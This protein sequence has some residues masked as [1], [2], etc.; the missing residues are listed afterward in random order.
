MNSHI[1]HIIPVQDA[2]LTLDPNPSLSLD[3]RESYWNRYYNNSISA[4]ETPSQFACFIASEYPH[5]DQIYDIGCGNGRDSIFFSRLGYNVIGID[6]SDQA[7]NSCKSKYTN[8]FNEKSELDF[9][10]LSVSETATARARYAER[11]GSNR[12]VVYSRFFLHAISEHEEF[13]FWK[14]AKSLA[15]YPDDVVALEFR[16]ESDSDRK[17]ETGAHYRRYINPGHV[18]Q[19]AELS[20]FKL[21]YEIHGRGFAKYKNDDAIVSR[22]VFER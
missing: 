20:G 14:T 16:N 18:V 15:S 5:A 11:D 10:C 22:L 12:V 7:I 13:D 9:Y 4:P 17:K 6:A 19:R 2:N 21:V 8:D 3:R 1:T